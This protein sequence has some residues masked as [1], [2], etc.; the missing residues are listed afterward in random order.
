[1]QRRERER[2]RRIRRPRRR[3][4]QLPDAETQALMEARSHRH[5]RSSERAMTRGAE[6]ERARAVGA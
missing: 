3:A 6:R 2:E 1:V 4:V 5:D